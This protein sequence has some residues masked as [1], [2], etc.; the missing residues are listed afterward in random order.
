MKKLLL[1]PAFA[2]LIPLISFT[3]EIQKN[4]SQHKRSDLEEDSVPPPMYS[5]TK[6]V[7]DS[8]L[9]PF[10]SLFSFT[11]IKEYGQSVKGEIKLSYNGIPQTVQSDANGKAT[12]KIKPGKYRFQFFYTQNY[13]EIYTDSISVKPGF[14]TEMSICFRSAVIML[15]EDKPVIY[16]Y[17]THTESVHI[18]LD[19]KGKLGFTYPTYDEGWNFVADPDG[20]IHMK[21]KKYSYLFWEGATE[22]DNDEMNWNDG[23]VVSK[24]SLVP[25]F[26]E[27]LTAMGLNAKEKD[28]YITYWVPRMQVNEKNYVHFLFNEDYDEYAT[29]NVRPKPDNLFQVFMLWSKA[30]TD[31]QPDAQTIPTFQREGFTVVEWGGGEISNLEL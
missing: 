30:A 18:N 10:E 12:L 24:D 15:I 13:Y 20:T 7:A 29:M 1:L 6:S 14:R 4:A 26:E 22:I 9:T 31:M 28:D 25:F 16:V 8:S 19:L 3:P 5:V 17:P 21:D 27:K 23:F 11:F 2:F